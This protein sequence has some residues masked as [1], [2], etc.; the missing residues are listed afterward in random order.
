G[1]RWLGEAGRL[2]RQGQRLRDWGLETATGDR[3]ELDPGAEDAAWRLLSMPARECV[4][5]ARCA[6][7]AEGFAEAARERARW[8]DIVVT[9]PGLLAYDRVAG[10]HPLPPHRLLVVE[11]AHALADRVSSAAQ[12]ELSAEGA[13][14]AARRVRSLVDP[15]VYEALTE[16]ADHLALALADAPPGRLAGP[17]PPP[18]P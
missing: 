15:Q 5:A 3:D 7:G 16:A 10:H 4:R 9:S 8:A 6:C 12:A 14:R 18:L 2:G 17:L 11:E 1:T 13:D